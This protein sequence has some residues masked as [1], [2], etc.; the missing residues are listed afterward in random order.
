MSKWLFC[1]SFVFV[2]AQ[3]ACADDKIAF[4]D[5]YRHWSHVKS[6][7][8]Y[9]GHALANPFKGIHHIYANPAAVKGL[10][11]SHYP[12][13]AVLVFDLLEYIT[14]GEAGAEGKRILRGVMVRDKQR[15]ANTGGWG[16][17]AWQGDSKTKR[18]TD[19]KGVSCYACHT[20]QKQHDF[21]FS[22][23]RN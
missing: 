5:G 17:E 3:P 23:W 20:S 9:E 21:V 13:G 1:L 4:P 18:L 8:L 6:L 22:K 14:A 10:Q 15:F 11:N 19:D 16:F 2:I 7:T 12:D